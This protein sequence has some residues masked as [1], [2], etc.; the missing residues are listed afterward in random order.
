MGFCVGHYVHMK[1]RTIDTFGAAFAAARAQLGGSKTAVGRTIGVSAKT[2]TRWERGQFMP[3]FRERPRII[4]ALAGAAPEL[5]HVLRVTLDVPQPV[6]SVVPASP[7][8]LGSDAIARLAVDAALLAMAETLP[9]VA[10]PTLRGALY[11]AVE[12]MRGAGV[13]VVRAAEALRPA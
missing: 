8:V 3:G 1:T 2:V 7:A 5:L 12:R 9:G 11:A 4:E 10:I 6:A 13:D